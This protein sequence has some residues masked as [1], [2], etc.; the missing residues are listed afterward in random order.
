MPPRTISHP[1]EGVIGWRGRSANA[2]ARNAAKA[3]P[4]RAAIRAARDAIIAK[5]RLI[6][7]A[8]AATERAERCHDE[9]LRARGVLAAHEAWSAS[10]GRVHSRLIESREIVVAAEGIARLA[11]ADATAARQR[12]GLDVDAEPTEPP[13]KRGPGRPPKSTH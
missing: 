8:Q 3:D 1:A 2:A 10:M 13:A 4:E 6:A 12:A 5:D 11:A 9:V 7:E